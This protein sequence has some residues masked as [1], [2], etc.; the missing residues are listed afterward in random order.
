VQGE[1]LFDDRFYRWGGDKIQVALEAASLGYRFRVEPS[2]FILHLP[3][4]SSG[5]PQELGE[6][7]NIASRT[8]SDWKPRT[9]YIENEVVDLMMSLKSWETDS[10][11]EFH[12]SVFYVPPLKH[13]QGL[14]RTEMFNLLDKASKKIS[15]DLQGINA[16]LKDLDADKNRRFFKA[17]VFK[18]CYGT[19]PVIG[20]HLKHRGKR[21]AVIDR[22]LF[23]AEDQPLEALMLDAARA[24]GGCI[25]GE[26]E[27]L[28]SDQAANPGARKADN[29]HR[30][31]QEH[32]RNET[33]R[34]FGLPGG[35]WLEH[36][37]RIPKL[38]DRNAY[39]MFV[40]NSTLTMKARGPG[41]LNRHEWIYHLPDDTDCVK[42]LKNGEGKSHCTIMSEIYEMFEG[43]EMRS[44]H[45]RDAWF[46]P[47]QPERV[48]KLKEMMEAS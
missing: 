23:E 36:W 19:I 18:W 29:L 3:K 7:C 4:Q 41:G 1:G 8:Q 46:L 22:R 44:F 45:E 28:R 9:G 43:T 20:L 34:G 32:H 13:L 37:S 39:G 2:N 47:L 42:G 14:S 35:M 26:S 48:A 24:E 33:W 6:F 15:A 16:Y 38:F 10:V 12:G 31:K 27:C 40:E 30:W 25:R 5:C 17:H 11:P 21:L